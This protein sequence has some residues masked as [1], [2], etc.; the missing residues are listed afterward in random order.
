MAWGQ[1]DTPPMKGLLF[2]SQKHLRA[3]CL[4]AGGMAGSKQQQKIT[5][6]VTQEPR[7][8]SQS[9]TQRSDKRSQ[10]RYSALLI[11]REGKTIRDERGRHQ[12]RER[13][14]LDERLRH[15]TKEPPAAPV[16]R[17]SGNPAGK[18][19]MPNKHLHS[20]LRGEAGRDAAVSQRWNI[21]YCSHN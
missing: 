15:S 5:R 14:K 6:A 12:Q 2:Q 21:F 4:R 7:L 17:G 19:G 9:P 1:T 3:T 16:E 10:P 20:A 8:H 11:K 18:A 13:G